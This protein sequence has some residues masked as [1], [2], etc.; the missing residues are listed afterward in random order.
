MRILIAGAAGFLG[1]H[2]CQRLLAEGNR[3][4]GLDNLSTG[5]MQNLAPLMDEP[6]FRFVEHDIVEPFTGAFDWIFNFACP[7]SPLHYQ[8]DSL[9]TLRTCFLGTYNLLDLARK[10]SGRFFQAST[11]EVY[12]DPQTNPQHEDY[13][14]NVNPFGPRACYDEGKRVAETL[15]FEFSRKHLVAV[16]VARIFNTYGPRMSLEDGRVVSN[17]IVQ[18]LRDEDLTI[19]GSGEQTRSFCYVEDLVE[20][21]LKLMTSPSGLIEPV[22]LGN[23][24]EFTIRELATIVIEMT[25]ARSRLSHVEAAA[26]DPQQRRPD[27]TRAKNLLGW[28]PAIPLREGLARTIAYFRNELAGGR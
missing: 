28:E 4:T 12:G 16:K 17:F 18:A 2:L 24:D 14:G 11:S 13:Y 10:C 22:N 5:R 1:S 25:G 9:G 7:A 23:P 15:C 3:V 6:G 26:D 27:L 21:S 20:G 19:Y 8:A